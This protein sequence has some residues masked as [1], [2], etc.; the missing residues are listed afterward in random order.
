MV[1]KNTIMKDKNKDIKN[2]H[3]LLELENYY[4]EFLGSY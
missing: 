2:H 1:N 3:N 4:L